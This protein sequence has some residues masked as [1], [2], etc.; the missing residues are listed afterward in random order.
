MV[1]LA[2]LSRDLQFTLKWIA[3][4]CEVAGMVITA[5]ILGQKK[6]EF[7]LWVWNEVSLGMKYLGVLLE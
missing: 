2:S 5:S 4:E 1:L 6:E 3:T 7:T